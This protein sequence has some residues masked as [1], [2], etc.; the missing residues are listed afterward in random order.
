MRTHTHIHRCMENKGRERER[1]NQ[2]KIW[3]KYQHAQAWLSIGSHACSGSGPALA[4][5][6]SRERT[7][8]TER[9]HFIRFPFVPSVKYY[10]EGSRHRT[11]KAMTCMSCRHSGGTHCWPRLLQLQPY[12][13]ICGEVQI[14]VAASVP[15]SQCLCFLKMIFVRNLLGSQHSARLSLILTRHMLI[16]ADLL[17]MCP[18]TLAFSEV[19]PASHP[20]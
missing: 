3:A 12:S 6:C 5:P 20:D 19:D 8:H 4:H 11:T 16:L 1:D 9:D 13:H 18:Q 2:K 14:S 15:S 10:V 17:E 7:G